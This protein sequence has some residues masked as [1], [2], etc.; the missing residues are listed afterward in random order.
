MRLERSME[1]L[2]KVDFSTS[3]ND[4]TTPSAAENENDVER[5]VEHLVFVDRDVDRF[6]EGLDERR[7]HCALA[8]ANPMKRVHRKC[9]QLQEGRESKSNETSSGE[10]ETPCARE[11]RK[12]VFYG[13]GAHKS[14]EETN[15]AGRPVKR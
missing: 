13:D 11:E 6:N 4:A 12:K 15:Y 7:S 14:K 1:G 2:V 5:G 10:A 8:S 9:P 3:S